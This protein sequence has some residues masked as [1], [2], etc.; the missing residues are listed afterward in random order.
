MEANGLPRTGA[1][2]IKNGGNI[3][4]TVRDWKCTEVT[5]EKMVQSESLGKELAA[6][7]SH[8]RRKLLMNRLGAR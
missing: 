3:G 7:N 2:G 1:M 6:G 8:W 5:Q 4:W